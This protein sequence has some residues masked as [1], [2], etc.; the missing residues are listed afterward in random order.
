MVREDG[1]QRSETVRRAN[2]SALTRVLHAEGP[3]SRSELGRRTGLTRSGIRRLVGDLTAAGLAAEARGAPSGMPGR[4][5][6]L[7]HLEPERAVALALEIAVDSIAMAVVGMGGHVM[8]L[9]RVERTGRALDVDSS[10]RTS[11]RSPTRRR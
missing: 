6:P 8:D 4:P 1:G 9:A 5:S 3:L 11:P 2:L 7:V 10:P